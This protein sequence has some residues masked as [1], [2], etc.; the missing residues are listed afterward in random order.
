MCQNSPAAFLRSK[1]QYKV[2]MS[3]AAD[4]RASAAG[5]GGTGLPT[6]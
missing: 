4:C 6:P 2:L 3:Y 5:A 1:N